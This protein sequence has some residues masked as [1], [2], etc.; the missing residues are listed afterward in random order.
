MKTRPTPL[1]VG[2]AGCG[3]VTEHK[4]LRA[5]RDLAAVEVVA[6]ADVNP[7]RL[8]HVADRYGIAR[9]YLDPRALFEDPAVEAVGVCV[10]ASAHV[11]VALAAL[12][13]GKHVLVEKPLALSLDDADR[14]IERA[15][16]CH[17]VAQMGF[18]MRWHR[19]V[20]QAHQLL[21]EGA[22]GTIEAVRT[23]WNSPRPDR[24]IRPWKTRR[25]EGGGSL[26]EIAVH[27]FDLWRWFSGGEVTELYAAARHGVRDDES[28]AVTARIDNG[29]LASGTTSERTSHRIEIEICGSGGRLRADCMRFDGLEFA[30]AGTAPGDPRIRLR[31]LLR[32]LQ[33]LPSGLREMPR[34]ADY[35]GSYRGQWRGFARAVREETPVE[36]TLE[37]GRRALEI[38]I[39]ATESAECG[40]VVRLSRVGR[41][42][43]PVGRVSA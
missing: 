7:E 34:G 19:L 37:D 43:R 5:L 16:S 1:R 22:L 8:A 15:R 18:H 31:S 11:E 35:I 3:E 33:E 39:A 42:V 4:H 30:P 6:L 17:V 23:V 41:T 10:P 27:H 26:V 36:C 9:R 25:H 28:A 29:V 38:V 21:Q 24:N 14:L 2:L 40:E 32:F 13:A 12:D 20:R